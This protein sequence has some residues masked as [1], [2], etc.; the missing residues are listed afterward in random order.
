MNESITMSG[1]KQSIRRKNNT[2]C[3]CGSL[4]KYKNCC[5]L[6]LINNQGK[7]YDTNML[8]PKKSL[9]R[10][11]TTQRDKISE[12]VS[13]KNE[14]IKNYQIVD[15]FMRSEISRLVGSDQYSSFI[16]EKDRTPNFVDMTMK[17]AFEITAKILKFINLCINISLPANKI[18]MT[19]NQLYSDRRRYAL[20]EL[21]CRQLINLQEGKGMLTKEEI[22]SDEFKK[23]YE[24]THLDIDETYIN[25]KIRNY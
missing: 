12:N 8:D 20:K 19:F 1:G 24:T 7:I 3:E 21:A 14:T 25:T 2:K 18:G 10:K 13:L 9:P 5:G 11:I 23:I 15:E 22:S 4:K 16:E 17:E 6:K